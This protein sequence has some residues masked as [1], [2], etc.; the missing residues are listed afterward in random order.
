MT[1]LPKTLIKPSGMLIPRLVDQLSFCYLDRTRISQDQTGVK[2]TIETATGQRVIYLPTAAIAS[3]LLGPGTTI[4]RDAVTTLARHGTT[5]TFVGDSGVRCYSTI[6]GASQ[7]T[8]LLAAAETATNPDQRLAAARRMYQM[9]F[10]D[11]LPD[12]LTIAQLRGLEGT[13]MRTIYNEHARRAHVRFRRNY[14]PGTLDD[15][16]PIN[17]ALTAANT[18]LYGIVA[19]ALSSL[20]IPPRPRHHPH[21]P[22]RIA[23]LR[24]RRPLQSRPHYPPRL[25][26]RHQAGEHGPSRPT[27]HARTTPALAPPAPAHAR[28]LR[29]LQPTTHPP[30]PRQHPHEPLGR[31]G[32]RRPHRTELLNRAR[33][34]LVTHAPRRH[35]RPKRP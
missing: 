30:H 2:A 16:D 25:R 24:H 33:P 7:T 14:T 10:G 31:H 20:G 32:I 15:T 27:T 1:T 9:R 35:H 18:A 12:G 23:H 34:R 5:I 11:T 3:L 29:H 13:R 6:H 26:H 28:H 22:P 4:T 21:R 17:A 8:L 19:A